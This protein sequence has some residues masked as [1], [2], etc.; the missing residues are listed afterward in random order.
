MDRGDGALGQVI[1]SGAAHDIGDHQGRECAE[2]PG[3]DA[4]EQLDTDQPE[5]HCWSDAP[6]TAGGRRMKVEDLRP[7]APDGQSGCMRKAANSTVCRAIMRS[8]KRRALTS[9]LPR[10]AA[11]AGI[12]APIGCHSAPPESP[13]T[14]PMAAHSSPCRRS[15][16]ESP[17]TTKLY[18]R[19]KERLTQDE[20]EPM[21]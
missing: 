14:S 7:A 11:A 1:A 20:V 8:P 19:T 2:N 16:H 10:R 15:A 12:A 21:Q 18:D 4:V 3:A 9:T 6:Q 13:P 17:S 5:A